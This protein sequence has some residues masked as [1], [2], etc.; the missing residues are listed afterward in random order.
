MNKILLNNNTLRPKVLIQNKTSCLATKNLEVILKVMTNYFLFQKVAKATMA[1]KSQSKRYRELGE[2][3]HMNSKLIFRLLRVNCNIRL[4]IQ[5]L[6]KLSHSIHNL[7]KLTNHME[8]TM[9]TTSSQLIQCCSTHQVKQERN[10]NKRF[11]TVNI[12]NC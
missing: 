11:N 9:K 10:L 6:I 5:T 7:K 4:M 2:Q 8:F 12:R 1:A 3:F